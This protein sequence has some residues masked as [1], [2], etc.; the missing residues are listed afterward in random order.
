M[1][2]E[3]AP[4]ELHPDTLTRTIVDLAMPAVAENLLVMM[5][6]FADTLLIG[7]LR[8]DAALAAVGLSGTFM[9]V[10]NGLFEALAVATTA[11]VARFLGQ[12]DAEMAKQTAAQSLVLAALVALVVMMV[13]IS[14]VDDFLALMGAEPEVMRQGSLY[15]RLILATSVMSFPLMV[16]N[17]IMRGSG[18]TRRPMM[19]TLI[20]NVFNVLTAYLLV[21][22]P[23]PLPALR[24][25]GA[26]LATSM[27]RTLGG[28]LA[29]WV[30][31]TGRT[32]L[33][34][35]PRR[36][37]S[38]DWHLIWRVVRLAL[39]TA[40]ETAIARTGSLLFMRIVSA[41]GTVALAA[42]QI[43]VRVESL[44]FMPGWGL[45]IATATLV[46]QSLGARREDVAE[47]SIRRTLTFASSL[48][49][50]MGICFALF[51]RQIV[52]IFGASPEVLN[53]AGLAV[54]IS[55]LE[56]VSIA[57]QMV[58]AG[59]LRGAGDTRTPMVV[60][61]FGVLFFRVAVVYLFAI[62]LGWGLAGVW[63]GTAVDWTGRAAL[64]VVLFRRGGWKRVRL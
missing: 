53:L 34:I 42:H 36:L 56:Q 13:G 3:P 17:G 48:M 1:T 46:G 16:A 38:W 14:A 55:A 52:V 21:F 33:R 57:V 35:E 50:V 2:S 23:G 47:L 29:L 9:W 22:G 44:S 43:A 20:M 11:M 5:V 45:A 54:R 30:L 32:V 18:D 12:R 24:L 27:A 8:E 7:W 37:L 60:T 25:A 61:L 49:G 6:F 59:G 15:L 63:L 62:T 64:M 4:L 51:G 26:G 28:S 40:G 19:I 58:L 39:P 10:A 41:L 31:F